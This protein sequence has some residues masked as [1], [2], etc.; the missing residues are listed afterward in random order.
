MAARLRLFASILR[1]SFSVAGGSLA[2]KASFRAFCSPVHNKIAGNAEKFTTLNLKAPIF[3]LLLPILRKGI[4]QV[5]FAQQL[6]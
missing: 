4:Q 5:L 2:H 6:R 1:Y 3:A